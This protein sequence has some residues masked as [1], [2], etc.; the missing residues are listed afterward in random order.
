MRTIK[1]F[2]FGFRVGENF[3][4]NFSSFGDVIGD[5]VVLMKDDRFIWKEIYRC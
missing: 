2:E 4:H 1:P 5:F 3:A